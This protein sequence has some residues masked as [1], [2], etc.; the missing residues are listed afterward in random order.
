MRHPTPPPE[1]YGQ[2][3]GSQHQVGQ[4][5][6]GSVGWRRRTLGQADCTCSG[7]ATSAYLLQ[8]PGAAWTPGAVWAL[9][10]EPWNTGGCRQAAHRLSCQ[11]GEGCPLKNG[12]NQFFRQKNND[13]E[14]ILGHQEGRKNTGES[15]NMDKYNRLPFS[16]V[17]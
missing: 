13:R 11:C 14:G 16:P 2:G 17:H 3:A 10:K 15:R 6:M 8:T 5:G 1:C 12:P 9:Q 7:T 4:A